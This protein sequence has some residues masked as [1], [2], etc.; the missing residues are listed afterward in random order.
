M[1]I[2]PFQIGLYYCVYSR[3]KRIWLH[4]DV[5]ALSSRMK[6]VKTDYKNNVYR[7]TL[8]ITIR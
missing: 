2:K 8:Y 7:K 6:M 4:S 3:L 5:Y 1:I